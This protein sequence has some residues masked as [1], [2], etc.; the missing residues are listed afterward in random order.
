M[1]QKKRIA[2]ITARG[3][4]K[5][6][7]H[8]NIRPFCGRPILEYSIEAALASELFEEVMVSTDD[9]EIARVAEA[10]GAG[11]PFLRSSETAG[12]FATTADVL[13]EVV[14]EYE[15]QGRRFDVLCCLYPTAP[16]VTSQKLR[17]A[18]TLLEEQDADSVVPVV[19]YS[20]PPQRAFVIR[21]GLTVLRYPEHARSRSQDLEPYFHDC[22]QFYMLRTERLLES[23]QIFMEHTVSLEMP[24]TQVQDIDNE[25]DWELAELKYRMMKRG[26]D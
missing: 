4:S 15:K 6:I 14:R 26:V 1:E 8:K 2:V 5:R 16:F 9:G 13:L 19:R 12:D 3:G 20:F 7:P 25:T 17:Q 18:L 11:V 23:G 22:G 24:E 10:A 21:D